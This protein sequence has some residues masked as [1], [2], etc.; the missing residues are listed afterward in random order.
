MIPC[1]CCAAELYCGCDSCKGENKGKHL[2][3]TEGFL[4]I[5]PVCGFRGDTVVWMDL[6]FE[7][8]IDV[9]EGRNNE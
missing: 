9:I 7:Y 1:F 3:K 4:M 2:W 5:C 8:Y 6:E